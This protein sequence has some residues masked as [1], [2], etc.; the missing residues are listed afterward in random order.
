MDGLHIVL[1]GVAVAAASVAIWLAVRQGSLTA[2][3]AAGEEAARAERERREAAERSLATL[4]GELGEVR[5]LLGDAESRA[6]SLTAH[7]EGLEKAHVAAVEHE[8][9]VAR[10]EREKEREVYA[11]QLAALER[12]KLE[13]EQRLAQFEQKMKETFGALAGEALSRSSTQFLELAN[14]AFGTRASEATAELEKRR[15]AMESMVKPIGEA[16]S[17][18]EV[19]LQQLETDRAA[20]QA[21]LHA[22]IEEMLRAGGELRS[23][24]GKLARALSKPEVRGRYG[25]IQLRRVAELA[26]MTAYCDFAEQQTGRDDQG[27]ALRPDMVVKL[28]NE[29]VV[30]VDAKT[31]TQAYLDA[32]NASGA[33][34]Q[35]EHLERFARHV[36]EQVAALSRKQYWSQFEG[37][38][39][40]VVMFMPGD[41][42]LDAALARRPSLI[43][44]AAGAN[45]LIATP[46]T[47]IGLLR[48][49]AVGWRERGLSE[50]ARELF[51][52]G[53]QLH[54]R[55]AV[56]FEKI[57]DLGGALERSVAKYNE[58]VGSYESRLEPTL[59]KFEEA[60]ARSGKTVPALGRVD[61]RVRQ[62]PE[63][64]K[65]E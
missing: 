30:A 37:S 31:N 15:A 1:A 38:P 19:K 55:A 16:L 4:G 50:Q 49:V 11:A 24:T 52:L 36:S 56:A 21:A 43:E 7:A 58:F 54:E 13:I 29:R 44:E 32:V 33:S 20:G 53:R 35:E 23:E 47:L 8:Q 3:A 26:G 22:R 18:T 28:P 2:K 61:A 17:K 27:R 39:E 41:Q 6:A 62:L 10:G 48:A 45:V 46:A 51:D 9:R 57:A 25:E 12:S 60:G 65:N 34:E 59:R 42:F 64:A 5:R 14:Q 40:F 63:A